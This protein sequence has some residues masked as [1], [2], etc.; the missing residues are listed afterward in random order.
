MKMNEILET[1]DYVPV[2]PDEM[3]DPFYRIAYLIKQEIRK[4]KWV[5]GEK[6][7]EMTWAE[8]RKQWSA[9]HLKEYEDFLSKTLKM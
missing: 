8:A 2:P 6:G 3:A 5:E 4:Y 7:N 9:S 1:E